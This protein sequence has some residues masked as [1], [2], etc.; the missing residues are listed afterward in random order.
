MRVRP[1]SDSQYL[2]VQPRFGQHYNYALLPPLHFGLGLISLDFPHCSGVFA[3]MDNAWTPPASSSPNTL[4]TAWCLFK[5]FTSSKSVLITTTLKWVS[6]FRGTLCMW[7]SLRI[8]KCV[9]ENALV[10][11]SRIDR[12]IGKSI[13]PWPEMAAV[14]IPWNPKRLLLYDFL[15]TMAL[16]SFRRNI[17]VEKE[18][19]TWEK[20]STLNEYVHAILLQHIGIYFILEE[21]QKHLN[22]ICWM[23]WTLSLKNILKKRKKRGRAL[24]LQQQ[25]EVQQVLKNIILIFTVLLL[26]RDPPVAR[27]KKEENFFFKK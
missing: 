24:L 7:L 1:F 10:S 19:R 4:F 2:T 14:D 15:L 27:K 5:S 16:P 11:F 6:L 21:R 25:E 23:I 13:S 8:S 18:K 12:S 9:G 3:T 20:R 17:S 26:L 22:I